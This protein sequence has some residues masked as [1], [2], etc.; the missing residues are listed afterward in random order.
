MAVI[1][2]VESA[3]K[4]KGDLLAYATLSIISIFCAGRT[5]GRWTTT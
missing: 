1:S 5:S 3:N 4:A 2:P